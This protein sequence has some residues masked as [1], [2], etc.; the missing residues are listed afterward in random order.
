MSQTF[1][2]QVVVITGGAGGVGSVVTRH[3]AGLGAKIALWELHADRAQSLLDDLDGTDGLAVEVDLTQADSVDAALAKT[4]EHF[5]PVHTLLHIAGGF[6]MPGPVHAGHLD[7]WHKLIALN[8]TALYITCGKVAAHMLENGTHGT[9][10]A[11]AARG[12]LKGGKH[13]AA[14]AASK[15][16]ALRII[17]SMSEELKHEGI[18]VN[19]ISPSII[20]TPANRDAMGDANAEKWVTPQEIANTMAFLAS[21]AA[22]AI[23]GANV[24]IYK[25]A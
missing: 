24:E 12:G 22:S 2:D 18:R 14:Y 21:D 3:F 5:G 8:A 7:T 25:R 23:T 19:A 9:I 13:S 15:A 20:D 10:T 11:V 17:E 1:Q 4:V 6:A 16:A